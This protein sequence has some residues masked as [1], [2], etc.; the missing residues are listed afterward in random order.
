MTFE[1]YMCRAEKVYNQT[2]S[3]RIGQAYSNVLNEVQPKLAASIVYTNCD[4][5]YQN[6]KLS[7]FL[8][9]VSHFW[10]QTPTRQEVEN[11]LKEIC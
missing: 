9:V 2:P 10:G 5:F 1:R 3:F 11:Y 8:V 6:D 4:P 7:T